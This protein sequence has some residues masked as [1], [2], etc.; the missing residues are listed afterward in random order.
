MT[1][2]ES[3]RKATKKYIAEKLD[4]IKFRV[5]K[6]ERE[7]LKKH[8]KKMGESM[9]AFI[10]RAVKEA[11]ERDNEVDDTML[12]CETVTRLNN[13]DPDKLVAEKAIDNKFGF[14]DADLEGLEDV[15]FE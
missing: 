9:N 6:G 2:K 14:T 8:A 13:L 1:T 12:I 11:V 3:Q 5:P 15:E 7:M 4:E 10:Y